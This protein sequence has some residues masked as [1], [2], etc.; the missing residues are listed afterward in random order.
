MQY[1][2]HRYDLRHLGQFKT[3][4]VHTVYHDRESGSI[5]GPKIWKILPDSFKKMG[6]V[7]AF[8][9]ANMEA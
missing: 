8:K 3:I 5:L 6:S 9:K 7:E 1:I 2:E 4:S